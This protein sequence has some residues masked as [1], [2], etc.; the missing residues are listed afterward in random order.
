[1]SEDKKRKQI[2]ELTA[3]I[4]KGEKKGYAQLSYEKVLTYLGIESQSLFSKDEDI[5]EKDVTEEVYDDV[6]KNL[7]KLTKALGIVDEGNEHKRHDFINTIIYNIVAEYYDKKVKILREEQVDGED[8]KGPVEFIIVNEK[9]I[10]I[11]IEAKK[12]DWDQG[13]AQNLMQL[14]NAYVE[15]IKKGAPKNHVVYGIVTTGY[16]WEFIWCKGNNDNKKDI[17][18]N[19]IW[20]HKQKFDPIEMDLDKNQDQWKIRVTPLIKKINYM[21]DNSLN[22]LFI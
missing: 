7:I 20:K 13:R 9:F 11:I 2:Q 12:Q 16:T 14:Y 5:P 3:D 8:V 22:Q 4:F 15:N 21:I 10:L 18:S 1:M 17:K 19:L 6:S